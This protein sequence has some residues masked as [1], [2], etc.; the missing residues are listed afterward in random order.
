MSTVKTEV[1]KAIVKGR[2]LGH[3]KISGE[4]SLTIGEF[5]LVTFGLFII[6]YGSKMPWFNKL[7]KWRLPL[8]LILIYG[9]TW[10]F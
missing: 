8:G 2:E 3:E 10:M 6:L 4:R 1:K 5:V 9:G 7:G